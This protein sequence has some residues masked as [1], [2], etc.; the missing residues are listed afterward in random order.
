MSAR[1]AAIAIAIA[2]AMMSAYQA[3]ATKSAAAKVHP[4]YLPR[5]I[6]SP[7]FLPGL[8][9]GQ[10]GPTRRHVLNG[11]HYGPGA[12]GMVAETVHTLHDVGSPSSHVPSVATGNTGMAFPSTNEMPT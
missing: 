10:D 11:R 5:R 6:T 8:H 9:R 12:R 1:N 3:A 2:I 7:A 4:E